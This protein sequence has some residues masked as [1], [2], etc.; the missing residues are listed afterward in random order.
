MH[1]EQGRGTEGVRRKRILSRFHTQHGAWCGAWSH[2]CEAKV[3]S[4][5]LNQL[6]HPGAPGLCILMP[7]NSYYL[8]LTR[9][10]FQWKEIKRLD[11]GHPTWQCSP[12]HMEMTPS[13]EKEHWGTWV[14]QSVK[15]PTSAR[16]RSHCPWVR[17]PRQALGWWLRAWSLFQILCLPLSL[18]LPRFHALSLSVPKIKIKVE[19]KNVIL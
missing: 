14:A 17:A 3:K 2:D 6:C 18:P 4:Q 9:R 16:S 5:T 19:K 13:K 11:L 15:R 1:T 8:H 7:H 12:S 10:K